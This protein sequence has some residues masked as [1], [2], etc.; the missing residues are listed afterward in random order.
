MADNH[1]IIIIGAGPVGL[2]LAYA[3]MR[4]GIRVEVFESRPK[5]SQ[6]DRAA[7]FHPPT[8]ELFDEW[9][10]LE[11]L[12][13]I[14]VVVNG[15]QYWERD[16]HRLVAA[17]DLSLIESFTAH[18]YRLHFPQDQLT[19][20]LHQHLS[21][22]PL[23]TVHFGHKLERFTDHGTH[24]EVTFST[25]K[26]EH[27]VEGSYLCGADGGNSTV[28]ELAN[29]EFTGKTYDDRFLIVNSD[30]KMENILPD[31]TAEAYI[32][33]PQEWVITLQM[34]THTRFVFRLTESEDVEI[35]RRNE[36]VY[37]RIK[38][39]LPDISHN[40]L[41]VAVYEVQQRIADRF[42]V[43]QVVLLGDAAHVNNPITGQGLNSGIHDAVYLA[44]MFDQMIN[45]DGDERYL[46][47]YNVERRRVITDYI[48][49]GSDFTYS[50]MTA[51]KH[52]EVAARN[53]SFQQIVTDLSNARNFLLFASMMAD[54]IP[55]DD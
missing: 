35:A 24:V 3:L 53:E 14:S 10:M 27:T 7:T 5:I 46:E 18:P 51:E 36:E 49:P 23:A 39:F 17:F 44:D 34:K 8:L 19:K 50:M 13:S 6:Q 29:I 55:Q 26:G 41:D 45:G 38:R 42:V 25:A 43:G 37:R 15:L 31:C 30:A 28:R 48:N 54:R 12:K 11:T 20:L 47:A 2:T 9:G 33:D 52:H 22:S 4:K 1:H 40:I 21:Q 16:S 32:F